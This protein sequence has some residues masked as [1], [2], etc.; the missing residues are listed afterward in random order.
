M[1][2]YDADDVATALNVIVVNVMAPII[3]THPNRDEIYE[4]FQ[5]AVEDATGHSDPAVSLARKVLGN[6]LDAVD[7][8]IDQG[9]SPD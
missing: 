4:R 6:L 3:A 7:R 1:A 9:T 8:E 5:A 2:M